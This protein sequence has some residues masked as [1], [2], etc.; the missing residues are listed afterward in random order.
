M[1]RIQKQVRNVLFFTFCFI[2][3][4]LLFGK[5]RTRA[6]EQKVSLKYN[7][8]KTTLLVGEKYRLKVKGTKVKVVWKTSDKSIATVSQKGIVKGKKEG[9]VK[10]T[11]IIKNKSSAIE[12]NVDFI[13]KKQPEILKK[14]EKEK[15][16]IE[17]I[18][19]FR[20]T[21]PEGMK[22]GN[23]KEYYC[24]AVETIGYGCVA[25]AFEMSDALFGKEVPLLR[26]DDFSDIKEKIRIG[27]IVRMEDDTHSA[28]V[29]DRDGEGVTFVEGNFTLDDK[30]DIVHWDEKMTYEELKKNGNYYL[31]RHSR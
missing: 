30:K 5:E 8:K 11:A 14:T 31:S 27:D 28:V 21:Y 19:E 9:K 1:K 7:E 2:V 25:L 17:K 10:I 18:K 3:S 16:V 26:Y 13:I 20:I 6:A 12:L 22:W 23:S 15:E 24:G 29:I 4:F